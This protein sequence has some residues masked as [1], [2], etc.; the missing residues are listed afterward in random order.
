RARGTSTATTGDGGSAVHVA[1]N[2][3]HRGTFLL[4]GALRRDA[5][6]LFNDL[7]VNTTVALVSGDGERERDRFRALMGS[8]ASLHFQQSPLDKLE[9]VRRLQRE[10]KTVLMVGDGLNDAGALRQADVGVAVVEDMA[11]FS[12][13][14]DVILRADRVGELAGWMRFARRAVAVVRVSFGISAAYNFV[15]VAIAAS[16]NLSPVVCAVLMPLSSVTVVAFATGATLW[17]GRRLDNSLR[18]GAR[19]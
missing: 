4:A 14:S 17:L 13:A 16:G 19:P 10:G 2:G 9:F 8:E 7:P 1:I 6:R 18:R 15:G 12:P 3:R 5:D 11:S